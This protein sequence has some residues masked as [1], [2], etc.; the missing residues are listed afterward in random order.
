MTYS[1]ATFEDELATAIR[2]AV[3]NE[4]GVKESDVIRYISQE[5]E[6]DP[7]DI[8]DMIEWMVQEQVISRMYTSREPRL[9]PIAQGNAPGRSLPPNQEDW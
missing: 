7:E 3:A 9:Y 6:L 8:D 4:R 2:Q 1:G 5:M